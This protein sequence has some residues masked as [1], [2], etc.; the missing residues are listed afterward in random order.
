MADM[1]RTLSRLDPAFCAG[2]DFALVEASPRLTEIQ[3]RTLQGAAGR[4]EWH[5]TIDA[6]PRRPLLVVA[7][8][9]FDALPVRQFTKTAAGWRERL[10]GIGE[11]GRPALYGR[12]RRY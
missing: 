4:L 2:A 9:L 12:P 11:D 1:L 7:N 5:A 6:L 10:V 8:E 3:R